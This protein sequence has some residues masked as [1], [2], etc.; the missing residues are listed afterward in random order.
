MLALP[1]LQLIMECVVLYHNK[2]LLS[3]TL[4]I[5]FEAYYSIQAFATCLK[6]TVRNYWVK[7]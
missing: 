7:D 4:S 2:H 6:I 5:D 1:P 3:T